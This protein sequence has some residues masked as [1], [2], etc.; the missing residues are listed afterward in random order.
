MRTLVHAPGVLRD[1]SVIRRE[2]TVLTLQKR[3][4]IQRSEMTAC[5]E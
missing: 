4:Q 3:K 5:T 2:A 1:L